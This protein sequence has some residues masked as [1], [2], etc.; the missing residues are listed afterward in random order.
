MRVS[1][2]IAGSLGLQCQRCMDQ[3]DHVF[4]QPIDLM[5]VWTDDQS[6][7]VPRNVDPWEVGEDANLYELIED[8]ILLALPTVA[9]HSEG[10]CQVPQYLDQQVDVVEPEEARQRPFEILKDL[11]VKSDKK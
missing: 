11:T 9:M 4:Q 1:G 5:V 7:S 2:E 10:D 8:E 3:V 6:K